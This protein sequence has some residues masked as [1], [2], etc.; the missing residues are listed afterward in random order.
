MNRQILIAAAVMAL[1]VSANP[2]GARIVEYL[3]DR[4]MIDVAAADQGIEGPF[5]DP[6][7]REAINIAL[8][9]PV[10]ADHQAIIAGIYCQAYKIRNPVSVLMNA[11][12]VQADNDGKLVEASSGQ[13]DI[14]IRLLKGS[15][16]LRCLTTNDFDNRC[17]N[18]V[19]ISA[20]AIFK[21][22]D[23]TQTTLPITAEVERKGRVGGFCGHIARY[24]G[25]V[26]REAG[27]ALLDKALAGYK[28][29]QMPSA[30]N[31]AH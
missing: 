25:I 29:S 18:T 9:A 27:V 21:K 3:T 31:T 30:S 5:A 24:T 4:A 11:L 28:T 8:E 17:R 23:G 22:T 1:A 13:A 14:V 2:A 15:T 20:E 6:P 26:T 19:R 10:A 16:V 12:A 7:L